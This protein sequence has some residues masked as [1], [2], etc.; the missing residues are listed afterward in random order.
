MPA[1]DVVIEGSF[2]I[3]NYTVT[4]LVDGKQTG[5]TETYQYNQEVTVK[6]DAEREGYTFSGWSSEDVKE[7]FIQKLLSNS[8]AGRTFHMPAKNVVIEG[9]FDINSYKVTYKVDGKPVGE[10]ET[11][12]Y[13]TL[14]TVRQ[15]PEKEG[16]TF[17][18]W[19]RTEAF[20]MPARDI[21]IEGSYKINSYTVTYKVDGEQY[22]ETETYEYGAAVTLREKPSREGYTFKGWSYENGFKMPAG[23]VV[24]EGSYKIN[25]YTVTYKVD[26]QQYGEPEVYKYNELVRLKSEPTK[27]GYTFSH[28]NYGEDFLMPAKD[29]VIE[30][31]F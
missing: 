29:V 19:S 20:E 11:Y 12:N 9:S 13:G 22:G 24:I 25:S 26:G 15:S 14:V 27:E 5:E 16:Y 2:T 6:A 3:N 18:G 31:S 21:V 1:K 4:Y 10:V 23:D 7:N 28:W 30:G 8:I 17:S